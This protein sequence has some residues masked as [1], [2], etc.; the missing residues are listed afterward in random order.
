[1]AITDFFRELKYRN[2]IL[3]LFGTVCIL[4]GI[5]FFALARYTAV[6]LDEVN[7]WYKPFKFAMSIG[8]YA[9]TMAWYCSYLPNFNVRM[10]SWFVVVAFGFELVYIALQASKG[11]RSHFNTSSSLY[12]TLYALM[13]IAAAAVTAY[14][15]Y[16]GVLFLT[17][18]LPG[19]PLPYLQAIRWGIFI[20]IIFSFEG[21]LMGSRM[22]HT[23]GG[24]DGAHGLPVLNWSRKFGDPRVA[25]FI[26]M[27]ALQVLPFVA[28]YLVKNT[29]AIHLLAI[30][31]LVLAIATLVQSLGGRPFIQ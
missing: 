2:E 27:H 8:I 22:S 7:A 5:I 23:I 18:P 9:L 4:S 11:Q 16:I 30:A 13:G 14:T 15:A 21:F 25:H 6:M 20:F 3:F 10:F 17:N 19:L 28:A 31:Y 29:T 1:M 26:G 24:P 12:I